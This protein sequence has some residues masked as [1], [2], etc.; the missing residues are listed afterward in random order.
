MLSANQ[1][2]REMS[3]FPRAAVAVQ[4]LPLI[5]EDVL[6]KRVAMITATQRQRQGG[7]IVALMPQ[8]PPEGAGSLRSRA[9]AADLMGVSDRYVGD[10]PIWFR[11]RA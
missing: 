1:H 10:A 7:E 6:D 3:K 5:S 4:L 11:P 8:S 2:R 9:I